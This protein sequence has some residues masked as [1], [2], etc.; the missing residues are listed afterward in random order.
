LT[1][2]DGKGVNGLHFV[3][4]G[5]PRLVID[6]SL[7]T[8]VVGST[9]YYPLKFPESAPWTIPLAQGIEA[10]LIEAEA[11]LRSG[12]FSD[13][14]ADLNALRADTADTH[15][16]GLGVLG[17]DSTT[18]ASA[19]AQ[20]DLMFRER[21]FWLFG[22]GHR[23]GDLRR[24]VRQ[25]GRAQETVFPIGAY[26]YAGFNGAPATYGNDVNFPI[27]AAERANPNFHGCLSRG[28]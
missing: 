25:Y 18:S 2:A 9:L 20:V 19:T 24:M 7:G 11:A 22:T 15:V 5:D 1:V 27:A 10:R 6:S 14:A 16:G 3:G 17:A 8:T 23:L 26:P 12:N 4:A 28:A 13:W 21:A